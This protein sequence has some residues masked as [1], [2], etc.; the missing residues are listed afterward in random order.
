ME[1]EIYIDVE[2][3][4]HEPPMDQ[5]FETELR[6]PQTFQRFTAKV[7]IAKELGKLDN[8]DTLWLIAT[9]GRRPSP[10]YVKILERKAEEIAEVKPLPR[11][12][13]SLGERKGRMLIEMLKEKEE[14]RKTPE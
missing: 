14:R 8:P 12:K 1:Y 7:I 9:S 13:L 10:Y 6:E 5:E 3:G 11:R 4:V 2:K